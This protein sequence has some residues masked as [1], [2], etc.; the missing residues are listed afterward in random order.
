MNCKEIHSNLINLTVKIIM[1]LAEVHSIWILEF[2]QSVSVKV[3]PRLLSDTISANSCTIILTFAGS[4]TWSL[5]SSW[6]MCMLFD[7]GRMWARNVSLTRQRRQEWCWDW[8]KFKVLSFPN[9]GLKRSF[10]KPLQNSPSPE[11]RVLDVS[12]GLW[13]NSKRQTCN[14]LC[15][16][17]VFPF[18]W[19][20]LG[21]EGQISSQC[22]L[23][24]AP[25]GALWFWQRVQLYP[26]WNA[27]TNILCS[28]TTG[29]KHRQPPGGPTSSP[30]T[31][32]HGRW[33]QAELPETVVNSWH[34][35]FPWSQLACKKGC[36]FFSLWK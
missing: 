17:T 30:F 35:K 20:W 32:Q 8:S 12:T 25:Q 19:G 15:S 3:T 31:L 36:L 21:L 22:S 34:W 18:G 23:S 2:K 4:G 27:F 29:I 5:R 10:G 6:N 33:L 16:P 1:K 26:L 28:G 14:V 9:P 11:R 13:K 7:R 24:G